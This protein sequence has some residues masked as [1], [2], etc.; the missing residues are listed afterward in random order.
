[1]ST[2]YCCFD[3]SDE[4]LHTPGPQPAWNE[5]MAFAAIEGNGPSLFIRHGRRYNEGHIEVS[6]AQLGPDGSLDVAFAKRPL[7]RNSI[8]NGRTSSGGG[9][10]FSLIEPAKRWRATY[11]GQ[12]R[13]I[14]HYNDFA[15]NPGAALKAAPAID[16]TFALEFEDRGPLFGTG[17]NGSIPGGERYL[18]GRHYEST[19]HCVGAISMGNTKRDVSTYGFRD[20]SWGVRDMTR[21][22]F[23]RWFWA[24]I[25]A[26]TSCVGWFTR[27]DG[28]LHSSGIIL[29]NGSV[30][31]ATRAKLASTYNTG[32]DRYA[33]C[34]RLELDSTSG[35]IVLE[36]E[37]GGALPLRYE[38]EG[39]TTRGLEFAARV[40]G[41][42][43]PAWA[44]YWDQM[45]DGAPI[46]N[47]VA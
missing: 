26:K 9:L 36:I 16:C 31:V 5:S 32:P 29:R 22:E 14:P 38:N 35:D 25:D 2:D 20:H 24:Q 4:H 12:I 46:G 33:R 27:S 17:P 37:T 3:A 43:W 11:A 13:R 7:D 45:I 6:V 41:S 1:M 39:R 42:D 40:K 28:Q 8:G 19:V 44:E 34:A 23:T 15:A 21:V 47:S 18:S 10:T 30:E